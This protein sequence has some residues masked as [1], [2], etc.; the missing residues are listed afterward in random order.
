VDIPLS[1]LIIRNHF[2]ELKLEKKNLTFQ[3][4]CVNSVI[5]KEGICDK[6][7]EVFVCYIYLFVF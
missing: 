6:I 3:S 7:L 4:K 2:K 5:L 1:E